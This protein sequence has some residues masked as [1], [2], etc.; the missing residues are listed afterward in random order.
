MGETPGPQDFATAAV[1]PFRQY[2]RFAGRS[3]R[4]EFWSYTIAAKVLQI[5]FAV[6]APPISWLLSLALM[7][8]PLAVLVRRLHDV[9]RPGW[10]ALPLPVLSFSLFFHVRPD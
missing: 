2:A 6:V 4:M 7:L 5:V 10:W 3:S 1:L 9:D 8:P